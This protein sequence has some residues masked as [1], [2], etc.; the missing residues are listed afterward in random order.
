MNSFGKIIE[1]LLDSRLYYFL[2]SNNLLHKNHGF[3]HGKSAP[4]ALYRLRTLDAFK[5]KKIT[6]H[7]YCSGFQGHFQQCLALSRFTLSAFSQ[8]PLW[9]LSP[10]VIPSWPQG[11]FSFTCWWSVSRS[12]FGQPPGVA[13]KATVVEFN[14]L[15][16][17]GTSFSHRP[18]RSGL[19]WRHC[20]RDCLTWPPRIKSENHNHSQF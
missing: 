17:I 3:S 9:H 11:H 13:H 20:C 14:N 5:D 2:H 4:I 15:W 18:V 6:C 10:Q 8:W 19:R 12:Y 16:F 7:T 1:Q